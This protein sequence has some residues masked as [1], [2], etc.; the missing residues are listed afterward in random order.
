VATAI[1]NAQA[2]Q[3]LQRLA[4]EQAAGRRVATLVAR[5]IGP[6]GVFRA[7]AGEV[8][9]LFG[10]DVSAIVRFEDDGM[11]TVLGDVGGPHAAGKRVS[12]DEGYV[13]HRV[14]ETG[15]SARFDTDE[16][17]AADMPSLVRALGIRS[18]V[19][20]PIVVEGELWGAITAVSVESPLPASAER[21]LTEFTELVATAVANTHAREHVTALVQ[22]QAALR[23]VATLVAHDAPPAKV[24]EA[25]A[26]E[27]G[28]LLDANLT[29]LG[30][31]DDDAATAIG[32][33]SSSPEVIPVGTRSSLGG[34]NVL[35]IVAETG[36]PARLD[37]YEGATG[38][39]AEI[40][41]SF[42]W[43]SSI[44][45]PIT[46][47]G[48]VWGVMLVATQREQPFPPG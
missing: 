40:A 13:V 12:L 46:V 7:V 17:S 34:R 21:R 27:V 3:D 39:A 6:E 14:R 5:G 44:A 31:Y 35:S 45:A 18:A 15:R 43:R 25:V 32:S 10:A 36:R 29:V 1:S 8:G 24:F 19:A 23:H 20:S 2:R 16:P 37:D 11:V 28:E 4:D 33:W 22:E 48:R 26:A 30:R 42:G 9:V 41:R 47:D 38:E